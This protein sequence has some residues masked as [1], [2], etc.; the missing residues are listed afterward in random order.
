VERAPAEIFKEALV[1]TAWKV[2]GALLLLTNLRRGGKVPSRFILIPRVVT[3]VAGLVLATQIAGSA[4]ASSLPPQADATV[5]SQGAVR[6]HN[7]VAAKNGSISNVAF[8]YDG[9]LPLAG[10]DPARLA[11][12]LGRPA[13]VVTTSHQDGVA[14]VKAI[15][16]IGAKAYK[17]VQFFWAPDDKSYEGINLR[18]HPGWA[19]CR[20]DTRPSLGRKTDGGAERGYFIDAN[21]R[22]VRARFKSI[23]SGFKADGWDGVFIDRGQAATQY[24]ADA[25]GRPVWDRGSTCTHSPYRRGARFAG[26]YVN[27]L[28]L[29]HVVGLQAM[30]NNGLSPFDPRIRM[31]PNPANRYCRAAEWS[32]CTF[33]ADAWRNVD[34]VLNE[35]ASRPEDKW[36]WRNFAGNRRSER[37][38]SHGLR[39]VGLITTFTLGGASHQHR[40]DV[41]YQW[42]R[43]KL[44]NLA[45]AVN[46]GDGGCGG[47]ST[48]DVCNRYGVY[49]ELV[50]T[51]FGRPLGRLPHS[52]ACIGRSTIHCVWLRRY[53]KG[54]NV[55]NADARART[56][57]RVSLNRGSCRYVYD[58]YTKAPLA[59]NRCVHK[60]RV[61]MSAWS[62]HPLRYSKR[63]W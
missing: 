48:S 27:M 34:V 14:T 61:T 30:M 21:E 42:S 24:A 31:R 37:N 4:D 51:V 25:R 41:F 20:K 5:D 26:A 18:K 33:I 22:A 59:H 8:Y 45:V 40:H 39:T 43:I 23:L 63:P 7:P 9:T 44:F 56:R 1:A 3:L 2:G 47:A 60:V 13:I 11:A 15:H 12:H 52:R 54:V 50:N 17:Y 38:P 62:G 10:T 32:K 58:V 53:A 57:V 36:W 29:A 28:G 19:F 35:S 49:P 55:L 6:A 46:T 16:G